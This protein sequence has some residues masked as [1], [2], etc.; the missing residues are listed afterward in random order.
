MN[1]ILSQN[2]SPELQIQLIQFRLA[3]QNQNSK[4]ENLD[5]QARKAL[6][7]HGSLLCEPRKPGFLTYTEHSNAATVYF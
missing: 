6:W 3:M 7:E 1:I 2:C 4:L 5:L